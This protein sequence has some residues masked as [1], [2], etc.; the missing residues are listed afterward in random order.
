M[1]AKQ[2]G[3]V[4]V[5]AVVLIAVGVY[6]IIRPATQVAVTELDETDQAISDLE[7]YLD[8]ENQDLISGVDD[9]YMD[10]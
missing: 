4:L 8:F 7:D 5:I 3:A 1:G 2:M 9:L 10:W 6:F